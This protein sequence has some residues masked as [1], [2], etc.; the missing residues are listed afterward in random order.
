MISLSRNV[1]VKGLADGI[2]FTQGTTLAQDGCWPLYTTFNAAKDTLI[3]WVNLT[4]GNLNASAV[5]QRAAESTRSAGFT[6]QV[7]ISGSK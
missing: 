4:E 1:T 2:P 3:G 7:N 5:W 6:N